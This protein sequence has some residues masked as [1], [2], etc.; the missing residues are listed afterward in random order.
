MGSAR[1]RVVK[2]EGWATHPPWCPL[3]LPRQAKSTLGN[4]SL[5]SHSRRR[6]RRFFLF[7][8]L[9]TYLFLSTLRASHRV[10]LSCVCASA[11]V[12]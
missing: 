8:F 12:P 5:Q 4:P 11:R 2:E 6:S 3:T 7:F 9:P 10:S 1:V